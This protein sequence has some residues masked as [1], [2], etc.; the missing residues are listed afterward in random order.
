MR[1]S[2][3]RAKA[4]FKESVA[5][6]VLAVV[7]QALV[8]LGAERD[9]ECWV[10]WGDDPAGRYLLF[11]PTPAGLV[12]VNVRVSVPGEGP[13]A[14]GKV[15]R[16]S[17]VQLGELA[18]EIQGGHRLVTFQIENQVLNGADANADAIAVFA[19]VLFAAADGR[20]MAAPKPG[21]ASPAGRRPAGGPRRP[22]SAPRPKASKGSAA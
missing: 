6:K 13:R 2:E 1:F 15:L 22:A 14:G 18:V 8:G 10:V 12:Q 7:E 16:W 21:R 17:R 9:P 11:A 19:Q 3:Y 4:P 20:V 5:P